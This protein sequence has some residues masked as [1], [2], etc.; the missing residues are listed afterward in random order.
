MGRRGERLAKMCE[1]RT[2]NVLAVGRGNLV[3]AHHETSFDSAG[4]MLSDST[5]RIA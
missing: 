2:L 5:Q 3:L 1:F 4:E